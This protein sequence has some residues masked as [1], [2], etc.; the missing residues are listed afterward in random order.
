MIPAAQ[1]VKECCF[2]SI[3][4]RVH[5]HEVAGQEVEQIVSI[6]EV[7]QLQAEGIMVIYKWLLIWNV[8][9]LMIHLTCHVLRTVQECVWY[10]LPAK[11]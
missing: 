2:F 11:S 6:D 1:Q 8:L 4:C 10:E 5:D 9:T 3:I 7:E